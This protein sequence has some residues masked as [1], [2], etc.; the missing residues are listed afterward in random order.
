MR[1]NQKNHGQL[2][3][4]NKTNKKDMRIGLNFFF[5]WKQN[6]QIEIKR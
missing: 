1:N 6:I 4:K 2:A 5:F 3:F